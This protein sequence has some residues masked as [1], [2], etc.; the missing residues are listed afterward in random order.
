[1]PKLENKLPNSQE[2]FKT[3][4]GQSPT[5]DYMRERQVALTR[6]NF[7]ALAGYEEPMTA[8]LEAQ[9][10]VEFQDWEALRK[11]QDQ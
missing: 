4:P 10:P 9:L 8:E 2:E 6:K 11:N 5:L 1:M 7:L 3:P